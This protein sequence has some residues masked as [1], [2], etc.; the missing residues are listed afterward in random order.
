MGADKT[1]EGPELD[2]SSQYQCVADEKFVIIRL[3][4]CEFRYNRTLNIYFAKT[5]PE[6]LTLCYYNIW[7]LNW[8]LCTQIS[9]K[10][11]IFLINGHIALGG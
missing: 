7:D 3:Q 11:K 2:Q 5:T 9:S 1:N 6:S 8:T 10:L 4:S